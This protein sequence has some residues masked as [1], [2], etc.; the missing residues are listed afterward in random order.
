MTNLVKSGA[1]TNFT[2]YQNPELDALIKAGTF[3]LD[4]AKRAEISKQCQ[5]ILFRDAPMAYLYSPD[6][7][8][9]ARSN[10]TGVTRDFT[11]IVRFDR[12][13]EK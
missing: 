11:Q 7:T 10:I 6:W 9:A 3:E 5:E 8:V 4:P 12:L 2:G 1:F 13:T